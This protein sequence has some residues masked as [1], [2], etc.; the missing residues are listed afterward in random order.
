MA[1]QGKIQVDEIAVVHPSVILEGNVTVGAYTRIGAGTVITGNVSIGHHCVIECNTVIRGTNKI[2]SWV[3]IYDLVNIEGGRPAKLGSSTA[4]VPD[5]SIIGDYCWVNHGAT[6]HGSQL[7]DYAVLH[8]N[9]CL[10]YN[11]HIGRG[12]L[13]TNGSALHHDTVIPPNCMV[14]G[15]PGKI[16]KENI[17]DADRQARMGLIPAEWSKFAGEQQEKKIREKLGR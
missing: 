5:Q 1:Q 7:E 12:S 15:V 3:H 17:T 9:A 14:E 8:L 11:C 6:M 10:D 16:I 13:I 4:Q 2:G